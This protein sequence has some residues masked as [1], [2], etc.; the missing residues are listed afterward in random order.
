MR[1]SFSSVFAHLSLWDHGSHDK[2]ELAEQLEEFLKQL[3]NLLPEEAQE[4][5][6]Y[7]L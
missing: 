1:K 3:E 2:D 4:C 6:I 7:A 5:L